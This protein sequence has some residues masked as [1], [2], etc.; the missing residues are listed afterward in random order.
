MSAPPA[1]ASAGSG[2]PRVRIALA[3]AAVYLIWGSTYLGLRFALESFP[4]FRLGGIRYTLAGLLAYAL[5]RRRGLPPPRALEWRSALLTGFLL[6]VLGNGLVAVAQRWIDSGVTAV[7]LGTTS[8]WAVLFAALCG[9]RPTRRELAGLLAGLAGVLV[10]QRG[11]VLGG[12]PL[13]I[14]AILLAPVGWALGSVLGTRLPLPSGMMASGLQMITGG[15]WMLAISLALG[16]EMKPLTARALASFAYLVVFGSFV[17]FSAFQFL[18]QR[19]RPALANSCTFVN[20]V[21]ALVLGAL[22]ADEVLTPSHLL[23]SA[24]TCLAVLAVLRPR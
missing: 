18:L 10:L 17:A 7:V 3:L 2:I 9:E 19:T 20:P 15:S 13:G 4:P 6:F 5:A 12:S 8:L 11:D 21:V 14:I 16:E 23:G 1:S 22:L 24:L